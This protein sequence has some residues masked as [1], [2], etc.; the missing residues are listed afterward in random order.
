MTGG[1]FRSVQM[2]TP[3]SVEKKVWG[4]ESY[5]SN[6]DNKM[7]REKT[8]PKRHTKGPYEMGG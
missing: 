4:R 6:S 3:A 2:A 1:S 5:N 8:N 7:A